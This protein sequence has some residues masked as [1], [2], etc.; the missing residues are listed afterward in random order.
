MKK[1]HISPALAVVLAFTMGVPAFA[2]ED[3]RLQQAQL[4]IDRRVDAA[5]AAVENQIVNWDEGY[6]NAYRALITANIEQVVLG[7]SLTAG[8]TYSLPRGG[9][10]EYEYSDIYGDTYSILVILFD[11]EDTDEFLYEL[12]VSGGDI[13]SLIEFL[14]GFIKIAGVIPAFYSWLANQFTISMKRD[15]ESAD[16]RMQIVSILRHGDDFTRDTISGWHTYPNYTTHD[17]AHYVS[18][19]RF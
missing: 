7:Q 10:I 9:T 19:K 18:V 15:I 8:F 1:K 4:E 3:A 14:V 12:D 11:Q 2:A 16:G 13:G 17:D 6:R 5:M